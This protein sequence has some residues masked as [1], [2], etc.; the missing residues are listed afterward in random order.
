MNTLADLLNFIVST[1][2]TSL[3][4]VS[5]QVYET[6]QFSADQFALKVRAELK[7]GNV[8]QVRLYRT[9]MHTDYAYQLLAGDEPG[10]RWDNKEHFPS[11]SSYPHHFHVTAT[12]TE[13]SSLN[14]DPT[15]DLPIV[16]DYLETVS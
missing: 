16:L 2:E 15:H 7:S 4:C 6:E 13:S 3:L 9:G 10:V 11:I 5:V 1:L 8:L 12:Q 14:G